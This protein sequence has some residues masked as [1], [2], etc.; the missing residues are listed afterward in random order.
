MRSVLGTTT[1]GT[2]E[3]AR[4]MRE[5]RALWRA[6]RRARRSSAVLAAGPVA[7]ARETATR[8]ERHMR[9]RIRW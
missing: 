8:E 9:R 4:D 1:A 7:S 6:E 3:E 2:V 5:V